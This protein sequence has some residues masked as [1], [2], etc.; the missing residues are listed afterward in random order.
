MSLEPAD[1]AF[2]AEYLRAALTDLIDLSQRFVACAE[3]AASGSV[4]VIG[5]AFCVR[6]EADAEHLAN[7]QRSISLTLERIGEVQPPI[8]RLVD[9]V[10]GRIKALEHLRDGDLGDEPGDRGGAS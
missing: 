2:E 5:L 8:A 10:G 6:T 3:A 9:L 7:V 4:D 1:I